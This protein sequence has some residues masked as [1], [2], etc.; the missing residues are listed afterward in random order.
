MKTFKIIFTFLAVL[1]IV[2][3]SSTPTQAPVSN[4]RPRYDNIPMDA[5]VVT[6]AAINNQKTLTAGLPGIKV[7]YTKDGGW[8]SITSTASTRV[9]GSMSGSKDVAVTVATLHARRQIAEFVNVKIQSKRT[10]D[11]LSRQVQQEVDEDADDDTSNKDVSKI[12]QILH[13][14][15]TQSSSAVLNGTVV[16]AVD[17]DDDEATVT[18]FV[19]RRQAGVASIMGGGSR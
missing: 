17:V 4:P 19:D 12:V 7:T 8:E 2:G 5:P 14:T 9:R 15:I 18:V 10:V 3:C 1:S 11:E 16:Q 6:P 13:D